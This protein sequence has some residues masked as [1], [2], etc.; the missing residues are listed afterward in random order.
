MIGPDLCHP[1]PCKNGG[2]CTVVE[3]LEG[4][5][6]SCSCIGDNDDPDNFCNPAAD[7]EGKLMFRLRRRRRRAAT[8]ASFIERSRLLLFGHLQSV[9]PQ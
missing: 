6:P 5:Y 1:N 8:A 2:S 9:P 7:D 4:E 3:D